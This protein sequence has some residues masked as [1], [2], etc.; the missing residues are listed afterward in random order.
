MTDGNRFVTGYHGTLLDHARQMEQ[1]QLLESASDARWLGTG[2]YFFENN[3]EQAI[4]WATLR[5]TQARKPPAVLKAK[6]NVGTCLDLT[7]STWQV[8]ARSAHQIL[9]STWE[10]NPDARKDQK[11]L[12][13][14]GGVVRA[15]YRGDW[16]DYGKN[17][18]DFQVVEKAIQI[19]R[20][21]K[22]VTLDTV[23]GVFIEDSPLYNNSWFFESAHVAIAV[24]EPYSA[25]TELKCM[26]IS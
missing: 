24:R 22:N 20:D 3:F 2:I 14:F 8:I 4:H 18:L 1:G 26:E 10:E 9:E 23:R 17:Q 19:A 11:P 13:L 6:I 25:L 5:G 7:K 15:G 12:S 16:K 21:Q